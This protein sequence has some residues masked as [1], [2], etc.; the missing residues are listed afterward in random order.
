MNE[1]TPSN[2]NLRDAW[3]AVRFGKSWDEANAEFERWLAARDQ[4]IRN[5]CLPADMTAQ[6]LIDLAFYTA[7][8]V[9]GGVTIPAWTPLF[10]RDPRD[11]GSILYVPHGYS[12]AR[13]QPLS[14]IPEYRTLAPL[15]TVIPDDCNRVF[16]SAPFNP[17]RLIWVRAI[18]DA[19][20]WHAADG[21][22]GNWSAH[23]DQLIDPKPV[24][25]EE[26]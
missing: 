11:D 6:E 26:R 10:C 15:P 2:E 18:D 19:D 13:T 3:R 4:S 24:P 1:Y 14:G 17:D 5:E 21:T 7:Y 16:A 22:P 12:T 8:R 20:R 25:E 23:T 9:Q